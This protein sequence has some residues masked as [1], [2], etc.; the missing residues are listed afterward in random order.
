M[1]DELNDAQREATLARIPAGT[2]GTG[3]DIAHAAL[4]LASDE[5]N[6]VTGQ[7]LHVNGGMAMI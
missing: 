3:D 5:A 6:Y 7:T 4:Y 1:T 2:L